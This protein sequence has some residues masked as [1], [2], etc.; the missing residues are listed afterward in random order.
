MIGLQAYKPK[1]NTFTLTPDI[2]AP[3]MSESEAE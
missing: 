3:K 2:L 1:F